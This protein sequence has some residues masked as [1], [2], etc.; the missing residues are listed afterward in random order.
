MGESHSHKDR[1]IWN[2]QKSNIKHEYR[3]NQSQWSKW[4]HSVN[5][6]QNFVQKNVSY[7]QIVKSTNKPTN[8][9]QTFHQHPTTT[10]ILKIKANASMALRRNKQA[11]IPYS[12]NKGDS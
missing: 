12:T 4:F 11:T 5:M 10:R 7:A 3:A 1:Y 9:N 8:L 2:N 6:Y